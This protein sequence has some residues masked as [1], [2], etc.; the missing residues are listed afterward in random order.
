MATPSQTA[1][2]EDDFGASALPPNGAASSGDLKSTGPKPLFG[3]VS[4]RTAAAAKKG[5]MSS[6][7][8]GRA[9]QASYSFSRPKKNLFIKVH[10]SPAYTMT[11]VPVYQNPVTESYHYISPDLYESGTL[12]DRFLRAS[13][14]I[15]IFVFGGADGSFSLWAV[16][17]GSHSARKGALK[18]VDVARNRYVIVE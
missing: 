17:V 18:A 9:K 4:A 10:P 2:P 5:D 15:D 16:K 11:N 6:S 8:T 3:G 13:K 14:L 7:R 12:P 1:D